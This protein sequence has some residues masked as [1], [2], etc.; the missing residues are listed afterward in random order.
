M[1][2]RRT[3]YLIATDQRIANRGYIPS[4]YVRTNKND[5]YSYDIP[6][7]QQQKLRLKF[8]CT[9]LNKDFI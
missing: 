4:D 3:S 8:V 5:N 7:E 6:Q 2:Q 9:I 1:K